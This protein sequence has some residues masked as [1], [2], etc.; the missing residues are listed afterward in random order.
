MNLHTSPLERI[1]HPDFWHDHAAAEQFDDEVRE[2]ARAQIGSDFELQ[3]M[4]LSEKLM[5]AD[6]RLLDNRCAWARQCRDLLAAAIDDHIDTI[7]GRVNKV[8]RRKFSSI[9]LEVQIAI[10]DGL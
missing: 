1:E 5:G 10:K 7:V 8:P 9:A 2:E 3:A 4:L 6:M